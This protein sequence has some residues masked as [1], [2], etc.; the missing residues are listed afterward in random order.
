MK[1]LATAIVIHRRSSRVVLAVMASSTEPKTIRTTVVAWI[2]TQRNV[3]FG[4]FHRLAAVLARVAENV[5]GTGGGTVRLTL[6]FAL[7]PLLLRLVPATAAATG[8]IA[9]TAW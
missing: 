9:R 3:G 5:V 6:C 7:V 4:V 1:E 8:A 2:L